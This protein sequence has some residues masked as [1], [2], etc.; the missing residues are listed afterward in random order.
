MLLTEMFLRVGAS[1]RF[2]N[3]RR[4]LQ[5]CGLLLLGGVLPTALH[6]QTFS[7]SPASINF[8][9]VPVGGSSIVDVIVTNTSQI[10]QQISQPSGPLDTKNFAYVTSCNHPLGPGESCDIEYYFNPTVPGV[11][12]TTA[13]IDF[14]NG[15]F[16]TVSLSGGVP[17]PT[18]VPTLGEWSLALLVLLAGGLAI[19]RMGRRQP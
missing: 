3:G 17:V 14:G 11:L 12:S 7:V 16:F 4:L 10:T 8:G 9:P 2:W 6:A 18:A 13:P 15:V 5:L 1:L 19:H